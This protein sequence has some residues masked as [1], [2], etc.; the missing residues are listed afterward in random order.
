MRRQV[1]R[2]SLI[3]IRL[4][5]KNRGS[6][7]SLLCQIACF[8]DRVAAG[9]FAHGDVRNIEAA[10]KRPEKFRSGYIR[11]MPRHPVSFGPFL[12]DLDNGTLFR[13][14]ARLAVGQRGTLLLGALLKNP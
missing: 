14:G 3:S 8:V 4:V 6:I 13:D 7:S 10:P 1:S 9:E 5:P 2:G 12:L 11:L